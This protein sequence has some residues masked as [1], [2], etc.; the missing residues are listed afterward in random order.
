MLYTVF[1]STDFEA[2]DIY[3]SVICIY[4]MGDIE[5][6]FDDETSSVVTTKKKKRSN[7]DDTRGGVRGGDGSDDGGFFGLLSR[8]RGYRFNKLAVD[9]MAMGVSWGA[10][11]SHSKS[12]SDHVDPSSSRDGGDDKDD[13]TPPTDVVFVATENGTIM[14]M[15]YPLVVSAKPTTMI[16]VIHVFNTTTHVRDL[17][18][19][20]LGKTTK[21]I[22]VSEK[23]IISVPVESCT[24]RGP[25]SCSSSLL[26]NPHRDSLNSLKKTIGVI[27][28]RWVTKVRRR[29]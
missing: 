3:A 22:V 12:T 16:E 8:H 27:S 23:S 1:T 18:L 15:V 25:G 19:V 26:G 13:G 24:R 28:Y 11:Q 2:V 6:A 7:D 29:Y 17:K 9:P 10:A 4:P 5:N 20:R 21:L 14:R